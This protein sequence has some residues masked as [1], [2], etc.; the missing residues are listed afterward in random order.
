MYK[1]GCVGIV[2][3]HIFHPLLCVASTGLSYP[4]TS[5]RLAYLQAILV[6]LCAISRKISFLCTFLEDCFPVKGSSGIPSFAKRRTAV[7]FTSLLTKILDYFIWC[8]LKRGTL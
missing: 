3:I 6:V 5:A 1:R 7:N 4:R 8:T 2:T